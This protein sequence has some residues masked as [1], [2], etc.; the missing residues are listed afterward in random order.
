MKQI[1]EGDV[2]SE[3]PMWK[4]DGSIDYAGRC[5]WDAWAKLKEGYY[6]TR[7]SHVVS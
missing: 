3:R 7:H 2:T 6:P 1:E 5:E 4:A